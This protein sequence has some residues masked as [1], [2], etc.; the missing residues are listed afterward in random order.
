MA[1][2]KTKEEEIAEDKERL[3]AAIAGAKMEPVDRAAAIISHLHGPEGD[4][5]YHTKAVIRDTIIIAEF[6]GM[7]FACADVCPGCGNRTPMFEQ[8]PVGP[9]EAGNWVHLAKDPNYSKPQLCEATSIHH[10]I[11]FLE[12]KYGITT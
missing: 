9:N 12:R 5:L 10:R 8:K 1:R 3:Q 2:K 6:R 4:T 7:L 11:K